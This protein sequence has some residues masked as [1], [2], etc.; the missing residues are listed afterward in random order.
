MPARKYTASEQA[1]LTTIIYSDIFSFPLTKDELWKFLISEK[2]IAREEF[3]K[4]LSLLQ[5]IIT[6]KNGYY[7]LFGR[8]DIIRKRQQNTSEVKK[9]MKRARFAAKKLSRIPT[10]VFIGISGGLAVENVTKD[11]DIDLVIIV[12]TNTLFMSRLLVLSLL[13][14]LGIRRTRT[15]KKTAD[16]ICTNLFFDDSA[17]SWFGNHKDIYTAREIAQIVPLFERE[18]MYQKFIKAN[19]WIEKY[20]PNIRISEFSHPGKRVEGAHLGLKRFW[21]SQ[22]DGFE[23]LARK[24]QMRIMKTHKTKEIVTKHVLAFH[25]NDYRVKALRQ[26][27]LKMR[28]FGLL[29]NI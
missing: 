20:L 16:T 4:S 11:D 3:E 24:L 29:T 14:Y 10:I 19:I 5:K 18:E 7:C 23:Y 27:R 12:K 28:Q 25:P 21:T 2:K 17:L 9:K 6:Y 22:N 1:I 13:Q 8:E 26:L 15:L